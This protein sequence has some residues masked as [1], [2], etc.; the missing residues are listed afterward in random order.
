MSSNIDIILA[1]LAQNN[2]ILANNEIIISMLQTQNQSQR[3]PNEQEPN[4]QEPN[5]QEPKEQEPKEQ[6][7]KEQEPQEQEPKEQEPQEQEPQEQEPQE[8]IQ[9]VINIIE[10]LDETPKKQYI[11]ENELNKIVFL[12]STI[13][14]CIVKKE[15]EIIST[16]QKYRAVLVDIW[17]IM[18]NQKI[19]QTTTFNL[20]STIE[21]E[22][23]SYKWCD[24]IQMSFQNKDAKGTLKEILNMVKVNNFSINLTI[25]LKTGRIIHFKIEENIIKKKILM[26]NNV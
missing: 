22:K 26:Y 13:E 15:K 24:N 16:K 12:H 1:L 19:L 14:E 8:K 6:E 23:N 20:K 10:L 25:K 4:E 5:E 11:T 21:N 9:P 7:P 2:R 17:K 3:Q 18:S